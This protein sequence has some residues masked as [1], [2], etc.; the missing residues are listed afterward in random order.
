MRYTYVYL[1][2]ILPFADTAPK[3]GRGRLFHRIERSAAR[4]T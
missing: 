2:T 3:T 1:R 4:S